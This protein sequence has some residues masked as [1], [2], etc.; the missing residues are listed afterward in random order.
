M[1]GLKA[2]VRVALPPIT[3]EDLGY[4]IRKGDDG[5]PD[6]RFGDGTT[7]TE[8]TINMES[9][10][11]IEGVGEVI[12]ALLSVP[13]ISGTNKR[14]GTP[15]G[16]V[17]SLHGYKDAKGDFQRTSYFSPLVATL[18]LAEYK[19][20][21]KELGRQALWMLDKAVPGMKIPEG[22]GLVSATLDEEDEVKVPF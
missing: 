3:L 12:T 8:A 17:G 6:I 9:F 2:D 15:Y 10:T 4:R 21:A 13:I 18:V 16:M 19:Q 5:K 14:R 22:N 20:I 7:T 1:E 11:R